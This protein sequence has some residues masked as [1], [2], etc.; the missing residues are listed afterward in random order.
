MTTSEQM[1]RA[2]EDSVILVVDDIATN[3]QV[4]AGVL[5]AAGYEVMPA[6]SGR[7]A[8]ERVRHQIPDLILLDLMMP[9]MGGIE[10]CQTL[11]KNAATA[12]VP[13]IFL[14]AS[15]ETEHLLQ[16]FEAGAVDYVTKPFT[17]AELLARVRT[18]LELKNA[19]DKLARYSEQLSTLN[20]EKNE[21][22]GIAA[23]DLR[24]PLSNIMSSANL[25]LYDRSMDRGQLDE[26]LQIIYNSAQHMAHLIENLLDVNAIE[27]GRLKLELHPCDVAALLQ[28]VAVNYAPKAHVKGQTINFAMPAQSVLAMADHHTTLQVFDNLVSNAVKYSQEGQQIWLEV[29]EQGGRVLVRIRDEGPRGSGGP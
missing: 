20:E 25:M 12:D 13:V 23:H 3:I 21:F 6:T 19:R 16:A 24:S 27:G 7:Q 29:V 14:T 2:P 4:A 1:F 18:H 22:L 17:T 28:S 10:V 5:D 8:L 9:E 11:K 15:N 26:F